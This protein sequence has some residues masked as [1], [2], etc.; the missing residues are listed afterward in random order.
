MSCPEHMVEPTR[1]EYEMEAILRRV[2]AVLSMVLIAVACGSVPERHWIADGRSDGRIA[3]A[4]DDQP[5]RYAALEL[6]RY[7][8]AAS[9]ATLPIE[10]TG[11]PGAGD[12]ILVGW[13][14]SAAS[15]A[16][17]LEPDAFVL[18]S[19]D[20]RRLSIGGPGRGTL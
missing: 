18:K 6:Q 19:I 5:T 2:S 3:L 16:P 15:A 14:E 20:G 7:L 11:E 1:R 13:G 10:G 17:D 4:V 9:G 8:A 12:E